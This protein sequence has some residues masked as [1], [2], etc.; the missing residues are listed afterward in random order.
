MVGYGPHT[1]VPHIQSYLFRL[2]ALFSGDIQWLMDHVGL[3]QFAPSNWLMKI[4]ADRVC[5]RLL[6]YV[7]HIR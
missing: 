1:V 3:F 2:L 6:I 4:V 7:I 5:D